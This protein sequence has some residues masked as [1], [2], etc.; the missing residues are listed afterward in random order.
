MK[1]IKL[2]I[3]E[4]SINKIVGR[5]LELHLHEKANVLDLIVGADKIIRS[6]G[7]FPSKHYQSLLH[8]V[9]NP[10]EERFYEQTGINAY[11][12]SKK[13]L[14]VRNNPKMELPDGAIVILLPEGGCITAWEEV[15]D[16]EKFKEAISSVRIPN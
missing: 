12:A 10:V 4:P 15:L 7:R 3:Q 1:K 11:T 13:F 14:D 8:C 5:E 16:Y 6:R 2:R 9:Y